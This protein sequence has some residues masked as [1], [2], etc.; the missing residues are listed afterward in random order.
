MKEAGICQAA[1]AAFF[2]SL[3]VSGRHDSVSFGA[4]STSRYLHRSA[5]LSSANARFLSSEHLSLFRNSHI[6][7]L[8][9]VQAAR[10][11]K[12]SSPCANLIF[13]LCSFFRLLVSFFSA[14]YSV[15]PL[16][17]LF[18]L[19]LKQSLQDEDLEQQLLSIAFAFSFAMHA[20]S[21]FA[22]F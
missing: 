22:K 8:E 10:T 6:R 16:Q 11:E 14:I 15:I 4:Q 19:F 17:N 7:Y 13:S 9:V 21:H 20:R 5:Q 12:E 1:G 3:F 2:R 18:L